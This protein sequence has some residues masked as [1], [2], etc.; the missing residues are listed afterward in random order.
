[1]INQILPVA[2]IVFIKLAQGNSLRARLKFGEA[3][4]ALNPDRL[5]S[6]C[7]RAVAVEPPLPQPLTAQPWPVSHSSLPRQTSLVVVLPLASPFCQ[8]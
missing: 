7:T 3:S 2:E 5:G 1:M 4:G 8:A 6:A